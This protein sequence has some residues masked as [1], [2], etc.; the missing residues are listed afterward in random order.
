[1][2]SDLSQLIEDGLCTTLSSLL[3]K[4]VSLK[5]IH[6]I[7][8]KDL[9]DIQTLK[10]E[11]SFEFEKISTN[12]EFIIPAYSA[13][14]I[15]NCMLGDDSEPSLE[16]DADIADALG[17]FVSNVSGGLTT[18][19]NGAGY[20]D[21]TGAKFSLGANEIQEI[22]SIDDFDNIFKFTINID[23]KEILIFIR[24]DNVI[25]PFINHIASS[26]ISEY[27]EEATE[28]IDLSEIENLDLDVEEPEPEEEIKEPEPP[29]E[30]EKKEE[31]KEPEPPKEEEKK[32]DEPEVELTDEEKKAKKLK[33]II[34]GVGATLGLVIISA[35]VMYF[36]GWF[37][38]PPP[39]K[40]DVNITKKQK[41]KNGIEVVEYPKQNKKRFNP[42]LINEKRLN[43][44]LA[45]LLNYIDQEDTQEVDY[46]LEDEKTTI[47]N[48]EQELIKFAQKGQEE[49]VFNK[50]TIKKKQIEKTKIV[51][52]I[53]KNNM[54]FLS[55][56]QL[57][58]RL[59]KNA[60]INSSTVNGR[61]S[62]CKDDMENTIIYIG[63]FE[64]QN[65]QNS[66]LQTIKQNG[67]NV[68]KVYLSEQLFNNRC[69]F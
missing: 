39:P 62:I 16:V 30:E 17:E 60:L 63:P 35:V 46:N 49:D 34:I 5:S 59:Y 57:K 20:E 24:F 21:L 58:Y 48:K 41:D 15:F 22:N 25:L 32:E 2:A 44:R 31:P 42:D 53:D 37:D 40:V 4:D 45:L 33:L 8:E 56:Q 61:V 6:K 26:P 51:D 29:K 3:A 43:T 13:S 38:P 12:W 7:I 66:V 36:L 69:D 47:S 27:P 28:D 68:K 9:Q 18:A 23:D 67:I 64:N 14:Y 52:K 65:I 10:I 54:M 1:M 11:T 50:K 19:I 55:T